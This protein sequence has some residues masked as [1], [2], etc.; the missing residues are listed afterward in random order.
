MEL[1]AISYANLD[2]NSDFSVSMFW[3]KG[4]EPEPSGLR[5]QEFNRRWEVFQKVRIVCLANKT[6]L[7]NMCQTEWKLYKQW[8]STP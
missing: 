1:T 7:N 3:Y 2:E 6:C 4:G 8:H 5:L